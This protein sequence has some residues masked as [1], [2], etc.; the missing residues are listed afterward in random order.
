M[1]NIILINSL[2]KEF[3]ESEFIKEIKGR[4]FTTFG[5]AGIGTAP[6]IEPTK[7]IINHLTRHDVI[8]ILQI[9]SLCLSILVGIT[10][11]YKFFKSLKTEKKTVEQEDEIELID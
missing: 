5:L 8:E 6:S 1:K 10:V 11:L 4:L 7:S 2:F 9:I 3:W